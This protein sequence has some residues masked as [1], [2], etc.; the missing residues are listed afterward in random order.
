MRIPV[1]VVIRESNGHPSWIHIGRIG[2]FHLVHSFTFGRQVDVCIILILREL[3]KWPL[4]LLHSYPHTLS[5]TI[6]LSF[7]RL[8]TKITRRKTDAYAGG[9]VVMLFG[10]AAKRR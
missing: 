5:A 3:Y 7:E 1:C 9:V 4:L 8:K 10:I 2:A 6:S